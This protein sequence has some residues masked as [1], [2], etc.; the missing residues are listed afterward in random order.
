MEYNVINTPAPVA[1]VQSASLVNVAFTLIG[2]ESAVPTANGQTPGPM[3]GPMSGPTSGS[4][5]GRYHPTVHADIILGRVAGAVPKMLIQ[6]QTAIDSLKSNR[7]DASTI[8][9]IH[10]LLEDV[11]IQ[12]DDCKREFESLENFYVDDRDEDLLAE[13]ELREALEEFN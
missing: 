9:R 3:S 10:K 7:C 5:V 11:M 2:A 12:S 8:S 6:P 13:S 1:I 4:G